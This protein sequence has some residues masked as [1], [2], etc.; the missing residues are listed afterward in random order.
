MSVLEIKNVS[1]VINNGVNERKTLLNHVDLT[2]E[3]G[4]FVTVLG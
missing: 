3:S 1:K 4:D 2:L